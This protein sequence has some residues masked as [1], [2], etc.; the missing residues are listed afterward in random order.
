MNLRRP[1]FWF[2]IFSLLA[3]AGCAPLSPSPSGTTVQ[4]Q[5]S[6]PA[7]A[8]TTPAPTLPTRTT[9]PTS[10]STPVPSP[11]ITASL[12][13]PGPVHP[14][15]VFPPYSSSGGFLLGASRDRAWL[16]ADEAA[17]LLQPQETYA[18]YSVQ[19][20]QG[21]A[22]SGVLAA[23]PLCPSFWSVPIE[24]PAGL[25]AAIG[26]DWNALPRVPQEVDLKDPGVMQQVRDFLI[27]QAISQPEVKIQRIL[28]VDLEGDGKQEVLVGASRFIEETG[29]DT[30]PG[31]YSIILLYREGR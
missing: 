3:A 30:S 21:S 24:H 31:D 10:T 9:L 27:A 29:H 1:F 5:K 23:E 22:V 6:M 2:L 26:A 17:A 7:P 18:L 20:R 19:E 4:P 15:L 8:L 13:T 12:A 16:A 14:I 25:A 28:R 11:T